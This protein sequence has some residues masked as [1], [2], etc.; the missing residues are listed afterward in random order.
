MAYLIK[1]CGIDLAPV[2]SGVT[3]L[4]YKVGTWEATL[5]DAGVVHLNRTHSTR[6]HKF[7]QHLSAAFKILEYVKK[8]KP[9]LVGL[10]DYT[11]QHTTYVGFS[12]GELGGLIRLLLWQ[13]GY[14]Q[15][16]ITPN[17]VT[18]LILPPS[19]RKT[20]KLSSTQWKNYCVDW[21]EKAMK[22]EFAGK[23][24]ERSDMADSA[25][26]GLIAACFFAY[27]WLQEEPPLTPRQR[28]IFF[29]KVPSDRS[30]AMKEGWFA[31]G[32]MDTPYQY[33][34][35]NPAKE[36]VTYT[37]AWLQTSPVDPIFVGEGTS[38]LF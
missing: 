26:Y 4:N 5:L 12:M 36:P 24:K 6:Q 23:P 27:Y 34:V 10:E 30:K 22:A 1:T 33:L 28:E 38:G 3:T 9:D 32:L 7:G 20:K 2:S 17:R 8:Q 35:R 18:K 16:L 11:N 13:E 21:V 29:N 37:P 31:S 14:R 15:L 25:I 19:S